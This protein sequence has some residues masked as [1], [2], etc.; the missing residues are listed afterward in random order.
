M[1]EIGNVV[2]A[3][4]EGSTVNLSVNFLLQVNKSFHFING[5]EAHRV[6]IHTVSTDMKH[7][8]P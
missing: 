3:H 7:V 1:R 4:M 8:V 5:N 6:T 2:L